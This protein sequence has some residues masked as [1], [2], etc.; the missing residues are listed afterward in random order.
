MTAFVVMQSFVAGSIRT[1][2]RQFSD[3]YSTT[4]KLVSAVARELPPTQIL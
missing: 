3:R 2:T 1:A 4:R